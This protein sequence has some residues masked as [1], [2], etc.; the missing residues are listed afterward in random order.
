MARR[1]KPFHEDLLEG[2]LEGLLKAL[3]DEAAKNPDGRV[4]RFIFR[5]FCVL[6]ILVALVVLLVIG[7]VIWVLLK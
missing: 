3:F 4:G 1:R 2:F 5:T 6:A 7:A